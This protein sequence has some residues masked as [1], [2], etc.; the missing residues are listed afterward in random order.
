MPVLATQYQAADAAGQSVVATVYTAFNAYAGGVGEVL[1]VFLLSATSVALLSSALWSR[2]DVPRWV[3][4]MGWATAL[5]LFFLSLELF[6]LDL[7]AF[8]A[9]FSVLYMVWMV[10][11]GAYLIR[12]ARNV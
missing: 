8:I 4:L 7:S 9:P 12:R 1:G 6:G 3:S 11:M 5:G 2:T 10:C